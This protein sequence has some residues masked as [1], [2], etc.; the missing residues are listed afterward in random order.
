MVNVYT[1]V[2][3]GKKALWNESRT[4]WI[5]G[6]SDA[7]KAKAYK[8]KKTISN[9]QIRRWTSLLMGLLC[10]MGDCLK[11]QAIV[12]KTGMPSVQKLKLDDRLSF[13]QDSHP[14]VYIQIYLSLVLQE[15][16][17]MFLS[18]LFYLQI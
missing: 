9:C 6:M 7:K 4:F 16:F 12:A 10:C 8:Q 15:S 11:Y 5:S 3:F 1:P 2:E 17:V 13:L 14:K 18:G